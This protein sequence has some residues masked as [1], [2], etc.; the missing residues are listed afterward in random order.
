[1]HFFRAPFLVFL[2]GTFRACIF[3][4]SPTT[5]SRCGLRT[6]GSWSDTFRQFGTMTTYEKTVDGGRA[7]LIDLE[8]EVSTYIFEI[9]RRRCHKPGGTSSM[10]TLLD[11]GRVHL[12]HNT[13][14]KVVFVARAFDAEIEVLEP[15]PP[16]RA[17]KRPRQPISLCCLRKWKW[18]AIFP[19][20]LIRCR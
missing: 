11:D 13:A 3:P 2:S 6:A 5:E 20:K 17:L 4:T 9:H 16:L 15:G 12:I 18:G 19:N 8:T 7:H 10:R 14:Q 1:M